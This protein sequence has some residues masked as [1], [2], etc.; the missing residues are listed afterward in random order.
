M[1]KADLRIVFLGNPDFA[2]YHLQRIVEEGYNVVAVVSAP[3]KP[4]GRGMK[5]LATPV[6]QYAREQGIP[7]LQPKNLK[8]EDFLSELKSYNAHLQV[9]IAF[10]MLPMAVWDMPPLGTYN[11]HASLLPQYRG[12]APINW[13]I[14]NGETET[15]V[16]TFK[17]KHE[18]DT[19]NLIVQKKCT[20]EE[21]DTAG[22]LHDKLM[23]LGADAMLETLDQIIRN[24]VVEIPQIESVTLKTASKLYTETTIINWKKTTVEVKNFVR[25]LTPYPVARTEFDNKNLLVYSISNRIDAIIALPGTFFSDNKSY[26][27]VQCS[28]G[29]LN[30]EEIKLE[31]K[32]KMNVID[33]LNGY[34]ISHLNLISI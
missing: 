20:I 1:N 24:E 3:D 10:R 7:C 23:Y 32:R 21:E 18:I 28:D 26:L 13:A 5:L 29:I 30:L 22:S 25:G 4:A 27:A 9:V 14:I 16:S 34:D 12:A 31:G 17:L 15:G 6:T 8:N 19:G 33:L 2:K 11:L